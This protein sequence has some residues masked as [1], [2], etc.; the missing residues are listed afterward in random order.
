MVAL[1]IAHHYQGSTHFDLLKTETTNM[2]TNIFYRGKYR[3]FDFN[4]YIDIHLQAHRYYK[5]AE[6]GALTE[7]IEKFSTSKEEFVVKRVWRLVLKL[8]RVS[9]T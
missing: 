2:M 7:L 4:K 3:T 5:Q 9:P 8:H 6:P 1:L